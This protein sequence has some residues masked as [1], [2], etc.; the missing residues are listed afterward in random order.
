MS[1]C[2]SCGRFTGPYATCPYCGAHL[3]GRTSLRMLKI[4]AAV[5]AVIGLAGLWFASTRTQAPLI[6]IGQIGSMMNMAYVRVEGLVTKG[7]DYDV[8]GEG[9][10]FTVN[11]DTG[12]LRISAYRTDARDLIAMGAIPSVGDHISVAGN[13]RVREDYTAMY[14]NAPELLQIT[15]P[16]AEDAQIGELSP[17]DIGRRV[18]VRGQVREVYSPYTGLTLIS[19]RD[20][21][22]E[23]SIAVSESLLQLTGPLAPITTGNSLEATAAVSLYGDTVQLVPASTADLVL[24]SG[25]TILA[26]A[27]EI[28][29]LTP[30]DAGQ[31]VQVQGQIVE[32]NPFSSGVKFTLDDGSGQ[33]VLL[34]WDS[35][36]RQVPYS[37]T[38]DVGAQVKVQG[39]VSEYKGELE[40][41]PEV[42]TDIV[43]LVGAPPPEELT[44]G[45]LSP[46]DAGRMVTLHGVVGPA[47]PFSSGVR[48]TLSDGTGEITLL[49]W[50]NVVEEAPAGLG[51]GTELR[52]LGQ[53]AEYKGTLEIVPRRGSDL[54]VLG[55]GVAPTPAPAVI[56]SIGEITTAQEGLVLTVEGTLGDVEIFSSGLRGPLQDD[57]GEILLL[58]W[59]NVVDAYPD[60]GRLEAGTRVRITGEITVYQG[61]L[62]IVPGAAG[63]V[64]IE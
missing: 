12:E 15:R 49:L 13:V 28:G 30:S 60:A 24:L 59:Q 64:I 42:T 5:L 41:A 44:V 18:R 45:A 4:A 47:E 20:S 58:L 2:P 22:G 14:I 21:T 16:A 26:T 19:L 53:I 6:E 51:A 34:I 27:R 10:S 61:T 52:V 46:A 40:L 23:V 3:Q 54:E 50:S 17:L 29:T 55:Q 35:V 31:W 43:I 33:I 32:S 11:D 37:A 36:F 63:I 62:E 7:P 39:N 9:L 25:D 48:Y 38:L 8:Q 57:T 56:A 1:E